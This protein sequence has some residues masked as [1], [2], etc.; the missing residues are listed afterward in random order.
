MTGATGATVRSFVGGRWVASG[1]E[2]ID[3]ISPHT[4]EVIAQIADADADA[5]GAAVAA[6]RTAFD[7]GPWP[8]LTVAERVAWIRRLGDAYLGRIDELAAAVTQE[9][10]APVAYA[11]AV[12]ARSPALVLS[13]ACKL[14][15]A[16]PWQEQRRGP[17]AGDVV[18]QRLPVGVV[19]AITPWNAPLLTLVQKVVPALLAGCTVIVKPALEAPL[20]S[21]LFAELV[22][23]VG[24]PPGAFNLVTGGAA[25]G[26]DIVTH[27]GVDLVTFTGSTAAGRRVGALCGEHLKRAKLELGG[28]SAAIVL[29]DAD[30]NDVVAGLR[31]LIFGNSGQI[32]IAHSRVLVPRGR[33]AELADAFAA[34]AEALVVGDPT[35]EDTDLGPLVTR[36]QRERVRDHIGS[37]VDEGARLVTGGAAAPDE[38]DRGWYVRPTVFTDVTSSMR[39]AREEVFGPVA[40]LIPYDDVDEA[41]RIANDTEYGLAGSVFG[42]DVARATGVAT[43]LRAGTVGVNRYT[44]DFTVPFGGFKASGIGREY[45]MEGLE[46]FTETR[47]LLGVAE[48]PIA[49]PAVV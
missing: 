49:L 12:Q 27:P 45:G 13:T 1:G 20:S 16:F 17:A 25:A 32:C 3:V 36:V 24:L 6:A 42:A 29:D 22:E 44:L 10:G 4:E 2:L 38:L 37:A 48:V 34:V 5:I 39:I 21:L 7:T 46:A 19:A 11:T 8:R 15:E 18:V 28:K 14:A 47:A 43:Q 40:T 30:T 31:D 9:M 41:V 35:K 26:A 33:Q 23:E